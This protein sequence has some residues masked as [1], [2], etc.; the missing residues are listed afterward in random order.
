MVLAKNT[1]PAPLSTHAEVTPSYIGA[2][3]LRNQG[4]HS[5]GAKRI[6]IHEGRH[7]GGAKR[8]NIHEGRHSG[9][10]DFRKGGRNILL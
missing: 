1:S 2:A 8:N 5:G 6:N 3:L 7:S 9:E 4:R 10:V